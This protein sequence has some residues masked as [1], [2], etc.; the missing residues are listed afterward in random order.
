MVGRGLGSPL[1][2]K[3]AKKEEREESIAP[4]Y[5]R[6]IRYKRIEEHLTFLASLEQF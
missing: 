1:P 5:N 6:D 2:Q 3:Y 4:F